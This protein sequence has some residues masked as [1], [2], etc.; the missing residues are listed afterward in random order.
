MFSG[1]IVNKL[2]QLFSSTLLL[3]NLDNGPENNQVSLYNTRGN[4]LFYFR[5]L[6]VNIN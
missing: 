4:I 2:S 1:F 3:Y 6:F 5:F